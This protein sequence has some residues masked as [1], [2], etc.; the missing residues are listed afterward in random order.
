[1]AIHSKS[2]VS[3]NEKF[4]CFWELGSYELLK[5][6]EA[7]SNTILSVCVFY[8]TTKL[9]TAYIM[10]TSVDGQLIVWDALRKFEEADRIEENSDMWSIN[11]CEYNVENDAIVYSMNPRRNAGSSKV[12]V[13]NLESKSHV[14]PPKIYS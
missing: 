2:M 5:K 13:Y 14:I 11:C 8:R 1:M 6:V 12:C 3:I 10:T 4:V 7:H 9:S